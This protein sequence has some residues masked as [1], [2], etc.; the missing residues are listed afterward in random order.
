MKDVGVRILPETRL[1]MLVS[2]T[3]WVVM[4][5]RVVGVGLR[6]SALHP[7]LQNQRDRFA[8]DGLANF[9]GM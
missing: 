7:V 4:K 5:G 2:A 1:E 6:N 9:H 3:T 8:E